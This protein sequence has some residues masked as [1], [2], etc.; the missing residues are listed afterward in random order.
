MGQNL[1]LNIADKG[2][3]ISVYNRSYEKTEA[4]V[5]RAE[6]EGLNEKL[7]GFKDMK[8]FVMSLEK[9]RRV[10]ILVKAGKPVDATIDGLM[11]HMEE[12]DIIVDGGN[13][14]Y[15]NTEA[16]EKK[17]AEKG[18]RYMGMGVSGGEEGAR[19]GPSM[20][21][22]GTSE[23]YSFIE[24]IVTKVA[25][26]TEDG[27]CVTY[28]GSGGAGNFVKMVHNGI[29]Y[30]DMQLISEAYD[31]L[32]TIGGLSNTELAA[33]FAEWN[34]GELES[35]LIEISS[36]IFAKEDDQEGKT[37]FLLDKVVDKTGSKG[38]GKWTV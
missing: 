27:A 33:V 18:L 9:P 32:K 1:S 13:E 30:A 7:R 6:K 28:I 29:E 15:E 26:Q 12:G 25:A 5:H 2:F 11:E 4:T 19:R 17:V 36:I 21:P 23:A 35:F 38:T 14:W 31:V 16:R 24:P 34:K 8:D 37:G 3:D 20:M 22:G 10:I